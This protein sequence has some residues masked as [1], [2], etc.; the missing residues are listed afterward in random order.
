MLTLTENAKAVIT[1][2]ATEA[3]LPAAGGVRIAL[4]PGGDQIEFS[5]ADEP[6]DE[7]A[8]IETNGARIFLCP[9]A[10]PVLAEHELD[11]ADGG[12]GVGFAL[13]RQDGAEPG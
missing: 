2:I 6:R 12:D 9:S 5:L 4:N 10:A 13:R 1:G 3:G 11:A 7:D 8:I